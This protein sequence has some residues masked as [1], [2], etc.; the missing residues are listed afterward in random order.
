MVALS[1]VY[2]RTM[3]GV[4][5]TAACN[6]NCH[7]MSDVFEPVCGADNVIYFSPCYAGC[8]NASADRK[9]RSLIVFRLTETLH[10]NTN[11]IHHSSAS[12]K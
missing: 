8:Q 11:I 6:V 12:C 9:V 2:C 10:S 7:C 4:N 1:V 5:L 3:T